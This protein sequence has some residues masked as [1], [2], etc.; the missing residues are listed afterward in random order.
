MFKFGLKVLE[1]LNNL[2]VLMKMIVIFSSMMFCLYW[3]Q[4]L[5]GS[6]WAWFAFV[7]PIVEHF[8]LI[9]KFLFGSIEGYIPF[10]A[11]EMFIIVTYI[12][13]YYIFN[14]LINIVDMVSDI[15]DDANRMLRKQE[16]KRYNASIS[17]EQTDVQSKLNSYKIFIK[18]ELK[19]KYAK[20]KTVNDY[21]EQHKIMLDFLNKKLNVI[22]TSLEDGVIYDLTRFYDI[23]KVLDVLFK[24]VKSESIL[25]YKIAIQI[26]DSGISIAI[27]NLKF[28]NH[29]N[30]PNKI[31]MLANT[32]YRYN[33][34]II[35]KYNYVSLGIFQKD[36]NEAE[37]FEFREN[38]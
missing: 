13:V 3:I 2:I 37:V 21:N 12:L 7:N 9:S 6:D 15:Y 32:A 4:K 1:L 23:D 5:I 35:K 36:N 38:V 27:R 24:I 30:F 33:F 28:I 20:I 14:L 25:N 22:G 8:V 18:T 11:E 10:P 26:V 19:P 29:L 17:K 16:I 34:N 31:C